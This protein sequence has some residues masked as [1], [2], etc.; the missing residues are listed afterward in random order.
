MSRSGTDAYD[1]EEQ[2][3]PP[4]SRANAAARAHGP[5]RSCRPGQ[6]RLPQA[7]AAGAEGTLGETGT[8][9]GVGPA[10]PASG[11]GTGGRIVIDDFTPATAWPPLLDGEVDRPRLHRLEH[12]GLN[13][14]E[15]PL[16]K[17]L[18]TLVGTRRSGAV[19]GHA[20]RGA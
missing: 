1:S 14:V 4:V 2:V 12:P 10:W 17:D 11:T 16:A 19:T 6:G 3:P 7:P 8:D 15:L 18:A 5:G 13:A 20:P 9:C